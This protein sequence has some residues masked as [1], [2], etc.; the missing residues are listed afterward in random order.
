MRQLTP[1]T[2]ILFHKRDD[3][4]RLSEE[5]VQI[6]RRNIGVVY[7]DYKLVD[8]KTVRENVAYA[9]YIQNIPK[10]EIE[11]RTTKSLE[12]I[13]LLAKQDV[14]PYLLSGWEKQKVAIARALVHSPEFV[15]ADEPTGNLDRKSTTDIADVLLHMHNQWNTI[16]C[17]THDPQLV[18]YCRGR[19]EVRVIN[20]DPV[21]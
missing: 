14:L 8:R 17:I 6:Y 5:E 15:I 16:L 21:R 1:P 7:Q 11:E 3:L 12:Q 10:E 2:G 13:G 4:A 18:E 19:G 20:V 9:L